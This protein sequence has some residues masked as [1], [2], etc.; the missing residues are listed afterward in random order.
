ML[1]GIIGGGISGLYC[2]LELS[3]H[4]EVVLLDE[5]D[6]LGGRIMTKDHLELGAARFNDTH[7]L[8]L[9]LIKHYKL[10]P[11]AIPKNQDYICNRTLYK[12]IH[13]IFDS[14]I[15]DI[16]RKT[17]ISEELRQIS[18][19]QHCVNILGSEESDLLV[20][21]FG[22]YTEIKIM[23]AYDAIETFKNDFVS[24]SYYVLK[25][26]LSELCLRMSNDIIHNGSRI[27]T[28]EKVIDV[29]SNKI[30][31][32]Q[33][34]IKVDKIIF[35][36]KARQLN[37]FNLLKPIHHYLEALHEAPLLRIYAKYNKVWFK[38]LNRITTNQLLRQIIPI[39]KEN[40]IIMISYTDDKDTKPFLPLLNNETQLRKM[41]H[42][43]LSLLFPN[44]HIED[45]EYI[46]SYY[47]KVGTHA[48]KP[49]FNSDKIHESIINPLQNVYVCGEAYSKKQAWIEGALMMSKEVIQKIN[50]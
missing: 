18:F 27:Y 25:E 38:D 9:E 7:T 30:I 29:K 35:C 28:N 12:N 11:I 47:W 22:Y 37:D 43:Q 4:N 50:K 15:K 8:L 5:R 2:A 24:Q 14:C 48:W 42:N 3:K 20:S 45:P 34:Q 41:I 39:D 44:K 46:V 21:I 16:I 40:G 6:Y 13:V 31:T 33:R 1:I 36:T 23:N 17:K 32:K 10:T 19:Y 49:K 26:G